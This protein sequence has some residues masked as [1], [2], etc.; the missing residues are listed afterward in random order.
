[1]A[2]DDVLDQLMTV[3]NSRKGQSA[4]A[5]YT[6]KLLA[7]GVERIG[8]KVTEEAAELVEA[9]TETG[10]EGHEHF[11]YEAADLFYHTL[12]L[13]AHRDVPLD[14]IRTELARRFG[15]SGLEEKAS[16]KD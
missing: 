8:P 5:S 9:A 4:D 2:S 1:M 7:G 10:D 11:V 3:I 15:V 12:V 13:L 14:D 6:A 16:R